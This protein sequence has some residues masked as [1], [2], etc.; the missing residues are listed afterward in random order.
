[1]EG[2]P[3]GVEHA[4][5]AFSSSLGDA[6]KDRCAPHKMRFLPDQPKTGRHLKN[7]SCGSS[8]VEIE[9]IMIIIIFFE[10]NRHIAGIPYFLLNNE[11]RGDPFQESLERYMV[12]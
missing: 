6:E 11:L 9:E 3:T 12:V 1:M 8:W 4:F 7:H 5:I 10:I 2:V